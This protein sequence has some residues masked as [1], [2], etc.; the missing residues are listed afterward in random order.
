MPAYRQGEADDTKANEEAENDVGENDEGESIV[1]FHFSHWLVVG[2]GDLGW[3]WF[4]RR[5]AA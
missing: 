2:L 4:R 3:A 5:R 1:G